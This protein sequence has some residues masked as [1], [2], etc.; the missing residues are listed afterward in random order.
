[1]IERGSSR[2]DVIAARPTRAFDERWGGGFLEPDRWV[3]IV[4]E[5]LVRLRRGDV[6]STDRAESTP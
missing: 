6:A 4:Y 2:E 5:G 3:G 1:M